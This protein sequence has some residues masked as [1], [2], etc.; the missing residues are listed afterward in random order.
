MGNS[1]RDENYR[2][3]VGFVPDHAWPEVS[4][5]YLNRVHLHLQWV[6]TL[7]A[8]RFRAA[9]FFYFVFLALDRSGWCLS[10]NLLLQRTGIVLVPSPAVNFG[11]VGRNTFH[12]QFSCGIT[13]NFYIHCRIPTKTEAEVSTRTAGL[14]S[15]LSFCQVDASHTICYCNALEL[16]LSLASSKNRTGRK[17]PLLAEL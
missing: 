2:C 5:K 8:V 1:K 9:V 15:T 14:T 17:P 11:F 4:S 7:T 6:L 10:H 13:D 16:S 3:H 12:Y